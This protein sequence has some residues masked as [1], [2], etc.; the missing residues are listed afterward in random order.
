MYA[1]NLSNVKMKR[2]GFP[3]QEQCLVVERLPVY[4]QNGETVIFHEG[5]ERHI[6]DQGPTTKLTAYFE[7]VKY[8]RLQPLCNLEKGIFPNTNILNPITLDIPYSEFDS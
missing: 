4:L 8:K 7:H 2:F 5:K 6:V 3:L 1:R